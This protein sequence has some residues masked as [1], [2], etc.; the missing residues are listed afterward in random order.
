MTAAERDF[1]SGLEPL[2]R[3]VCR[4]S[5][6][7]R[8][9]DLFEIRPERGRQSAFHRAANRHVDFL[10]TGHETGRILCGIVLGG[11]PGKDGLVDRLFASQRIP[12][13][14]VTGARLHDA[15]GLG[16][17]LALVHGKAHAG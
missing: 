14:R 3:S 7:V 9:T 8:L 17:I 15:Q 12:L 13:F 4:I 11:R 6:K 1:L 16:D 5:I 10:L 2:V